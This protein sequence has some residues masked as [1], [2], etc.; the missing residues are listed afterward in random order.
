MILSPADRLDILD[1][2]TGAD[3]AA[4]D[5]DVAGYLA[6]FADD[7]TLTGAQ[8][9]YRGK[10]ELA[11]GVRLVWG[12]EPVG[13]RHLTLNPTITARDANTAVTRSVMV[14][15]G[16]GTPPEVLAVVDVDHTLSKID[17]IWRIQ[18]RTVR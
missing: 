16:G 6:L 10:A 9:D 8:G 3:L 1:V 14:M 12:R 17:G 7:A 11:N 18:N 4:G 5:R 2:L 15:L 13:T